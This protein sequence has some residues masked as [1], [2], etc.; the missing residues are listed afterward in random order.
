[1]L[2]RLKKKKKME[3]IAVFPFSVY[4]SSD[5]F[6]AI[7][8][9]YWVHSDSYTMV[10]Y[11]KRLKSSRLGRVQDFPMYGGL[12]MSAPSLHRE[13]TDS[14]IVVSTVHPTSFYII[15]LWSV[16]LKHQLQ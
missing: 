16:I 7:C 6:Y 11:L 2:G 12:G 5:V 8:E 9:C 14:L 3:K 4:N 13:S 15:L 10:R 1:M